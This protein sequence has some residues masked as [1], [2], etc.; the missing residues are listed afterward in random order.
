MSTQNDESG[1]R[2]QPENVG[3]IAVFVPGLRIPK[4]LDFAEPLGDELS[5]SLVERLSA[6]RTRVVVMADKENL[7]VT[8]KPR[9]RARQ[10]GFMFILSL[11]VKTF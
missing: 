2:R 7:L 1:S 6:L 11:L 4:P 8:Q 10:H 3:E 9:R 5:R